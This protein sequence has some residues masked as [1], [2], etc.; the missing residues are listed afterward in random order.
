MWKDIED[1]LT[2]DV[3]EQ[4]T[5]HNQTQ[6]PAFPGSTQMSRI[7]MRGSPLT[8]DSVGLDMTH[9]YQTP[10]FDMKPISTSH[11]RNARVLRDLPT[12]TTMDSDTIMTSNIEDV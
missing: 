1:N 9:Q 3:N 2:S 10:I 4:L 5:M 7:S 8:L 12:N 6:L 11:G